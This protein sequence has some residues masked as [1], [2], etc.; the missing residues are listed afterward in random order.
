MEDCPIP[1]NAFERLV[2]RAWTDDTFAKIL[3][4]D[5]REAI[6]MEL[7]LE[8]PKTIEI[9]VHEDTS[10]KLNLVIPTPPITQGEPPPDDVHAFFCTFSGTYC[11]PGICRSS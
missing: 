5:P 6:H 10:K 3:Y 9:E 8:V 11:G 7:G 1:A 4:S 2:R